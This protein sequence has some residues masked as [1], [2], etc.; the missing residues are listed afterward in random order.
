MPKDRGSYTSV[1][2]VLLDSPEY[3][4]LSLHAAAVWWALKLCPEANQCGVFRVFDDQLSH[5]SK[6]PLEWVPGALQ[7]LQAADWIRLSGRWVWLRNH[8]RWN[9]AYHPGNPNHVAGLIQKISGLPKIPLVREFVTYYQALNYLP[10]DL[11]SEALNSDTSPPI[12][13]ANAVAGTGT[14]TIAEAGAPS[15][16][17]SKEAANSATD[18]RETRALVDAYNAVFNAKITYSPGNLKAA[19]RYYTEGY[20]LE[21]ALALFEAVVQCK[22]PTAA[23]AYKNNH[24]FEYLVR[25][26]YAKG[27]QTVQAMVDRVL[28]ELAT[29]RTRDKVQ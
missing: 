18:T 6:V 25:P 29:G 12:A 24:E 7:E 5:R 9:P 17:K 19:V 3:D 20:V 13:I 28:N 4:A 10:A 11:E 26:T 16:R 23:W 2:T 21:D 22:G 1:Y 14:E 27:G 8:L 15:G